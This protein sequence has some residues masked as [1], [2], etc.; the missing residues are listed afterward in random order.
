MSQETLTAINDLQPI[1]KRLREREEQIEAGK[2]NLFE[3]ISD[4]TELAYEQGRDLILA[5]TKTGKVLKFSEWLRIHV[6]NLHA[7]QAAKYERVA[8]EQLT[9]PRQCIFAF[10]PAEEGNRDLPARMKPKP[11]ELGWG[12]MHKL[13][14]IIKTKLLL[15]WP[16]QQREY[17]AQELEPVARELW[18]ERFK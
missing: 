3:R 13:S 4:L 7:Q 2:R 16:S 9:D 15:D 10:L 14:S 8:T 1:A 6:P 11:W 18:P 5:K 12:Y 17:L